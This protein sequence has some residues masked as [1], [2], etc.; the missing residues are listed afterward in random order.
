MLSFISV[1]SDLLRLRV[2]KIWAMERKSLLFNAS[3]IH[4]R[5]FTKNSPILFDFSKSNAYLTGEILM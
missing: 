5:D 1:V 4:N 2:T 3:S